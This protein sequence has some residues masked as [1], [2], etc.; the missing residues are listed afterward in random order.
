M[1]T[2]DFDAL[3]QLIIQSELTMTSKKGKNYQS[4][5]DDR[6]QH[7]K[8]MMTEGRYNSPEAAL[9]GQVVKHWSNFLNI[10]DEIEA[11]QHPA[12]DRIFEVVQDI[13][14]YMVLFYALTQEAKS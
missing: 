8:K 4:V 5:S 3:H 11:G 9:K 10:I 1:T 14:I 12:E 13:R 7:F 2:K 6:L